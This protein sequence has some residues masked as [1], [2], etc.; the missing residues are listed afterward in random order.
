MGVAGKTPCE[1][2]EAGE[3]EMEQ[4]KRKQSRTRTVGGITKQDGHL[5]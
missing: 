5:G 2:R 1:K 3:E 4:M